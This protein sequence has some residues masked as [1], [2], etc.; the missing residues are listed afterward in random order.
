[1]A[2]EQETTPAQTGTGEGRT[3]AERAWRPFRDLREEVESLFDDFYWGQGLGPFRR[4]HRGGW[5]LSAPSAA[6][7]PDV[8]DK[9]D[10]VKLVAELPGM[11]EK[12]I[13]VQLTDSTLTVSGE[14]REE[15]EEGDKEGD[16]YVCER[17]CGS[18]SRTIRLPDG[19][20][21]DRIDATFRNG[22]FTVHL[23]KTPEARQPRR[24]IEIRAD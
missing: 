18:F 3:A 6:P 20:D 24:K 17:R 21:R 11:E 23:P 8:I 1:M 4:R 13:D 5:G 2:K 12:D 7:K 22:V 15:T 9:E 14:K 19:I 10:E 16:Y